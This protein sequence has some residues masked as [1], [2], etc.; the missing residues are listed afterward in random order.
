MGFVG[1]AVVGVA[2]VGDRV[3]GTVGTLVGMKVG[4][5]STLDKLPPLDGLGK[6]FPPLPVPT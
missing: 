1:L 4:P 3:G 6:P 5:W 2:E